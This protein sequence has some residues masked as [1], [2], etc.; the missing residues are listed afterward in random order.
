MFTG[1]YGNLQLIE[2]QLEPDNKFSAN[3]EAIKHSVEKAVTLIKRMSVTVTETEKRNNAV[4]GLIDCVAEE[5]F[6]LSD[7][8]IEYV[9]NCRLLQFE[10]DPDYVRNI[11]KAVFSYIK[12][13]LCNTGPVL[14]KISDLQDTEGK[15]PLFGY[16]YIKIEITFQFNGTAS[17]LGSCN[18]E[19]CNEGLEKITALAL[20]YSLLK[21]IGAALEV[22][23]NLECATVCLYLPALS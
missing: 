11:L 2:M 7:S 6:N 9:G 3:I 17:V 22:W 23:N 15:L 13:H 8:K 4:A 19:G 16:N 18:L 21:K 5:V 14:L 1:I 12:S 10:A 20:S